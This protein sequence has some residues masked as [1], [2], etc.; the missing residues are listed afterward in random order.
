[1]QNPEF[2]SPFSESSRTAS[3]APNEEYFDGHS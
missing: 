1:V 3:P 2:L